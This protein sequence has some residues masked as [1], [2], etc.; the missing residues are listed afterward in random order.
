VKVN[1]A[2]ARIDPS[3]VHH[4]WTGQDYP[5]ASK[6]DLLRPPQNRRVEVVVQTTWARAKVSRPGFLENPAVEA[7]VSKIV[8][9]RRFII[10]DNNRQKPCKR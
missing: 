5:V 10:G 7:P 3:R 8:E 2:I 1:L 4:A 6:C 9:D